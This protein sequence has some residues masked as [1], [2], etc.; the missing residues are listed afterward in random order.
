LA[1][2]SV[3]VYTQMLELVTLRSTSGKTSDLDLAD[4]RAKLQNA[5]SQLTAAR[6]TLSEAQRALEVL[7]G[8]YP[9]AEIEVATT[10]P[11]LPPPTGVGVPLGLLE[12]RPD[13]AAA[14]RE[15]LAA[16]RQQESARLSLLPDFSFTFQGGRLG[17][18][19]LSVLGLA[20]WLA[21]AAIGAAIPIFEGGA[22]RARV[23]IATAQ[24]AQAVARYGAVTLT[25][26]REV[27]NAIANERTLSERLD[28]EQ[29][30]LESRK[31]A[32]RLATIQYKNGRRDLLWVSALQT[33]EL[34]VE[35][36][37]LELTTAQ[38]VNRIQLHLALG[39]SFDADAMRSAAP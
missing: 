5:E 36:S 24:E 37:V 21:S 34:A 8:R 11:P 30:A 29:R 12:R 38:R 6:Q 15:V 10:Y 3:A 32:V 4:T 20:P 13:L 7:I 35:G 39:G 33:A 23:K 31:E 17:D 2:E 27:E 18:Q 14:E 25:A 22:L 16:F 26:F 19:I 9:S 28:W 1:E